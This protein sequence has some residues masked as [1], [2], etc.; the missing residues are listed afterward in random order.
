MGELMAIGEAEVQ[1]V[2]TTREGG[3]VA[4]RDRRF[5]CLPSSKL[6]GIAALLV[7]RLASSSLELLFIFVA[8]ELDR[9]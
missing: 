5:V 3:I 4:S 6:G 1:S 9:K 8:S 7:G 2:Q